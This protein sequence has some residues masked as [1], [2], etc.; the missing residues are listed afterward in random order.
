MSRW[1]WT[2]PDQATMEITGSG[3][4][5]IAGIYRDGE[6]WRSYFIVDGTY[7]ES[8]GHFQTPE[9]AA[10]AA[11]TSI[12]RLAGDLMITA[13]RASRLSLPPRPEEVKP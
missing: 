12:R 1:H 13:S 10:R 4:W 7:D 11:C 3:L 5:I 6:T 9:E 2:T 8:T